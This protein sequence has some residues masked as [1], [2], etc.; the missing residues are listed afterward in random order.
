MKFD[1]CWPANVHL[2]GKDILKFHCALWPAMLMSAGLPLPE[3]VFAHGFFTIDGQK[4]SKSLGNVVDPVAVAEK[5][6]TDALRYFLAREIP[7]G[8][9]GDFSE[10]RLRQRYAS[11]LQH[12]IGNFA[13]RTI[14]MIHKYADGKAP[15]ADGASRIGRAWEKFAIAMDDIQ[16]HDA[17]TVVD[18]LIR[19]GDHY[20]E[21]EHPWEL[22]KLG[23]TERLHRVLGN[24]AEVLRHVALMLAPFMP[25]TSEKILTAFGQDGWRTERLTDLQEWGRMKEGTPVGKL[26]HLFPMLS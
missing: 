17:L 6:G 2:V 26:E 20:I 19:A 4:M 16:P 10:E 1:Q 11:D 25:I 22:A 3:R 23:E 21:E 5:C 24:L 7:F 14:T 15:A 9:D 12:G 13:A 18:D 8:G